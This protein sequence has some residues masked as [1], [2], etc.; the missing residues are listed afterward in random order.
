LGG[1]AMGLAAL[2]SLSA[3]GALRFVVGFREPFGLALARWMWL[4]PRQRLIAGP[5]P[6]LIAGVKTF[7]AC[8]AA[9][10]AAEP[11]LNAHNVEAGTTNVDKLLHLNATEAA[12]HEA[13]VRYDNQRQSS[14]GPVD[15]VS[16]G[17]YALHL[18]TFIRAGFTGQQFL[19]VSTDA[20]G[21]STLLQQGLSDFIGLPVPRNTEGG[22]S[23]ARLKQTTPYLAATSTTTSTLVDNRS[24]ADIVEA[25]KQ[26]ATG[27]RV[28]DFYAA[29]TAPLA[30]MIRARGVK[31]LGNA[32]W[33]DAGHGARHRVRKSRRE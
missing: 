12:R 27:A 14:G 18:S 19:M 2:T 26:S 5:E 29:H 30:S 3:R 10:G 28:R 23:S 6:T 21:N 13:C 4:A 1:M 25:F 32:A 9:V 16:G 8:A 7:E 17:L 31:V 15:Q 24:I 22:C 33:L 11:Q 20:L